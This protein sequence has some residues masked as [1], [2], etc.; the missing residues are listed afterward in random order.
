MLTCIIDDCE[1]VNLVARGMCSKHYQRAKYHGQLDTVAPT[2]PRPCEHC[3]G[4]IPN[5]RRWGAIYCST[6]CKQAAADSADK[7]ARLTAR[8]DQLRH[9]VECK[10]EMAVTMRSDARFCSPKCGDTWNNRIKAVT[11][12][13]AVRAARVDR[14]CRECGTT[15]PAERHGSV[16][17]CVD[18]KRARA[19]R[20]ATNDA[21]RAAYGITLDDYED[22]LAG[23]GGGC[24][25]CKA[26]ES[27]GKG[28]FHVDHCHEG[29]QIRGL[30]CT[31]CNTGLGQFLDDPDR[32]RAAIAYLERGG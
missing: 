24:A 15:I 14:A 25:I 29:G 9:C 7:T 23:Q 18:C 13:R 2:P 30:L 21:L 22:M 19:L 17:Y 31:R 3:G 26:V 6:A 10:A 4:A 1:N 8:A 28:R 32:L 5:G 11:R 16:I 27:G 20:R 12:P